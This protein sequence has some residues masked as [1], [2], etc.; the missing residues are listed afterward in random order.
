MQ[1][2]SNPTPPVYSTAPPLEVDVVYP[3]ALIFCRQRVNGLPKQ[4]TVRRWHTSH[5]TVVVVRTY[6]SEL[7]DALEQQHLLWLHSASST[8]NT[9][10]FELYRTRVPFVCPVCGAALFLRAHGDRSQ[11]IPVLRR[12]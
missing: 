6:T 12:V 9:T 11:F 5:H 7:W 1:N 3:G 8:S 2:N 10:I 4:T